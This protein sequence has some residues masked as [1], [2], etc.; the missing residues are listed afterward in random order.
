LTRALVSCQSIYFSGWGS[1]CGGREL[2][3]A[4]SE[5]E[6]RPRGSPALERGGDP[7]CGVWPSSETEVRSRDVVAARLMG[8]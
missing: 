6:I 2:G 1:G 7:W 5:A 8:H 4:S 3:T